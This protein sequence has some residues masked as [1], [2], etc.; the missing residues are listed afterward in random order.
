MSHRRHQQSKY[1]ELYCCLSN[2]FLLTY[3]QPQILSCDQKKKK[4]K[5]CRNANAFNLPLSKYDT[6]S[7][8]VRSTRI[9][10]RESPDHQV[11]IYMKKHSSDK[12]D[13]DKQTSKSAH[14][15]FDTIHQQK[16]SDDHG[17]R[18]SVSC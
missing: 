11:E 7:E 3:P 18:L 9:M 16:I 1:L 2:E 6:K 13:G 5:T 8:G 4:K 12:A 14:K 15:V 17:L 10:S